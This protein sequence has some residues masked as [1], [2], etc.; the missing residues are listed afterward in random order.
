MTVELFNL[1]DDPEEH[2][3]LASKEPE[4]AARLRAMLHLWRK[5]TNARM[6]E[7]NPDYH[8]GP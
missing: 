1:R 6:M 4:T 3:N 7:P 5:R 8:P 2:H